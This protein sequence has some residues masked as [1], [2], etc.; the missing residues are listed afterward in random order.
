MLPCTGFIYCKLATDKQAVFELP[1]VYNHIVY[2]LLLSNYWLEYVD[3]VFFYKC[4]CMKGDI[5]FARH[6]EE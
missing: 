2:I 3:L 1:W 6:F 4:M 5:K